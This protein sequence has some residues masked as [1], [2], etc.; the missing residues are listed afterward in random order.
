V[1]NYTELEVPYTRVHEHK[2]FAPWEAHERTV[3]FREYSKETAAGDVPYYPIRKAADREL[4]R[5]YY[6]LA[7]K[8][9]R[10]SF[11]GRLGTYRYLDMDDVIAEALDF[12]K[13]W[14]RHAVTGDG[15]KPRFSFDPFLPSAHAAGIGA[16]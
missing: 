4:L 14:L 6:D 10:V 9:E 7:R 3:A 11:L 12:S 16:V 5:Q 1:I 15:E 2:H 8:E 13:R